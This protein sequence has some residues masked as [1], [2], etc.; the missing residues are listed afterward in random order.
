MKNLVAIVALA[1]ILQSTVA[2][3]QVTQA[4]DPAMGIERPFGLGGHACK[5]YDDSGRL[6]IYSEGM[7]SVGIVSW[8]QQSA[9]GTKPNVP[10]PEE[11]AQAL[12]HIPGCLPGKHHAAA[13]NG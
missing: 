3:A 8:M 4:V 13:A 5:Q 2:F 7:P 12:P 1:N 10:M 9:N 11:L 6:Y